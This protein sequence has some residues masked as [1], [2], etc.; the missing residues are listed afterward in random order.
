M[1]KNTKKNVQLYLYFNHALFSRNVNIVTQLYFNKI[2]G[3]KKKQTK[4]P[5]CGNGTKKD[6]QINGI[7]QRAQK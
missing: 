5:K 1:E 4:K 6:I 7:K 3:K 2:N